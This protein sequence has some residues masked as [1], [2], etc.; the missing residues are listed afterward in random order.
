MHDAFGRAQNNAL[1]GWPL[2]GRRC[3][4]DILQRLRCC[5]VAMTALGLLTKTK[6]SQFVVTVVCACLNQ[7]TLY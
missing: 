1:G 6:L 7:F 4:W 2:C 5:C 3:T